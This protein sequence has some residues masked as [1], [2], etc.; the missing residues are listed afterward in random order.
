MS[1]LNE[2]FEQILH[3]ERNLSSRHM[4]LRKRSFMELASF[5]YT[6]VTFWFLPTVKE[7]LQSRKA[8]LLQVQ[9]E[10]KTKRGELAVRNVKMVDQ[11]VQA[12]LLELRRNILRK[13]RDKLIDT[14]QTLAS[15]LV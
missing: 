9:E 12:K 8:A 11:E 10:T 5:N 6:C 2:L 15:E 4:K 13:Q 3:T 14:N 7:E 1:E